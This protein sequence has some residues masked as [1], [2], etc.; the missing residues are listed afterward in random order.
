MFKCKFIFTQSLL[1]FFCV[2]LFF[3][4]QVFEY[5]TVIRDVVDIHCPVNEMVCNS[6]IRWVEI[7]PSFAPSHRNLMRGFINKIPSC[8]H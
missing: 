3:Q 6:K 1:M 7:E 4:R 8:H 2:F 5:G